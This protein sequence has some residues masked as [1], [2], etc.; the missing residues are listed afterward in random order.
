MEYINSEDAVL[1]P[2]QTS[3]VFYDKNGKEVE[4]EKDCVA[5]VFYQTTA[6]KQDHRKYFLY[7]LNGSIYDPLG[8][9]ANKKK[10][11][12]FMLKPV[13]REVFDYY[14]MYLNTKN[15]LYLTR[16]QRSFIND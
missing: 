6:N 4:K 15:S 5:Q 1:N 7:T 12:N 11:M 14:L 3:R 16:A 10:N 13:S 9:D 8:M 2:I